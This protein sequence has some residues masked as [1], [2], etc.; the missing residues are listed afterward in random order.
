LGLRKRRAD[1]HRDGDWHRSLHCWVVGQNAD[2]EPYVIFQR[3]SESKDTSPGKLDAT[4]GG[5]L[6]AGESVEDALRESEEEIGLALSMSELLPLGVRQAA[7]DVEPGVKDYEIQF[8]F[9]HKSDMSLTD[10]APN[11]AEVTALVAIPVADALELFTGKRTNISAK[12]LCNQRCHP[13]EAWVAEQRVRAD[14]FVM[15]TDRYFYRMCVQ[16]DLLYKDFPHISI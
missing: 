13:N 14:D 1:V 9:L 15:Q 10:F 3:R 7:V 2:G 8:V 16:T 4:V 6:A 5:H 11:P 12:A